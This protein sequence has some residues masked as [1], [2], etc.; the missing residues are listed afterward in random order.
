[1]QPPKVSVVIPTY[2]Y[3]HFL[4]E[5]IQSVLDQTFTDF[6]LIIVDNRSTDNTVEVVKKYL[7]DSRVSFYVNET[8]VGLV[9]NWNKCLEY[10][11]GEYLKF[12]CADDKFAPQLLEKFVAIMEQYPNVSI[13]GSYNEVF[14]GYGFCRIGP[15]K[16]LTNG[17]EVREV[18]LGSWNKLRN[19]SVV[20]FRMSAVRKAGK[21]NPKLFKLTD[22][23][24]YVRLL[25]L[26]DCY[27][28]PESL[29]Y[30]RMHPNTQSAKVRNKK[31]EL[32]L[33]R[34]WYMT[35]VKEHG[36]P[37]TN[38]DDEKVD[39][40]I[41]KKA[42]RCAAVMYEMLPKLYKKQNR[43]IFKTAYQIGSSE[44]VLFTPLLHYFQPKY[45]KQLISKK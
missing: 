8:N 32:I 37:K 24:Y 45:I 18:L 40:D 38:P 3:G 7:A 30:V 28:I 6:E 15:F 39:A 27:I 42:I 33:E 43:K 12:L 25:T 19:P 9:G 5:T 13:V 21:F 20:M 26:G 11:T 4:D 31:H 41:K 10:A 16:G 29:S 22:R 35:S 14:G 44:G 23:E 34:Y 1:M 36:M 2:N 17:R